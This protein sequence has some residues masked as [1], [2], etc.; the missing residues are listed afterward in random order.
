[1]ELREASA[2]ESFHVEAAQ[3]QESSDASGCCLDFAFYGAVPLGP[4]LVQATAP[5]IRRE[6]N[7]VKSQKDPERRAPKD[8][9]SAREVA[10]VGHP[11]AI[12][13]ARSLPTVP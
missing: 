12:R 11:F 6:G 5:G 10:Q 4:I 13:P 9:V 8:V 3:A 1:M 7:A 2:G